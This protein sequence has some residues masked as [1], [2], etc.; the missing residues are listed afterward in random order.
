MYTAVNEPIQQHIA[1]H[2]N[3]WLPW[4]AMNLSLQQTVTHFYSS[5]VWRP[6][7]SQVQLCLV[8]DF[9]VHLVESVEKVWK[10]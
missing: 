10:K 2:Y 7:T 1:F 5:D 8:A 6:I 4:T 3:S 9:C